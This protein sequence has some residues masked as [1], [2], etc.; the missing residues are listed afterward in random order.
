M[1]FANVESKI[2]IMHAQRV[3]HAADNGGTKN[4]RKTLCIAFGD[5][6]CLLRKHYASRYARHYASALPTLFVHL[7]V[8]YRMGFYER[9]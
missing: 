8:M 1:Y 7:I 2:Y 3:H 6:M 9:R 5:I 4:T